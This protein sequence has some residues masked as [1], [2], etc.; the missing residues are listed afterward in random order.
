GAYASMG[1]VNDG[2]GTNGR[3]DHASHWGLP[4]VNIGPQPGPQTQFL[5]TNAD[6]AIFGG[7]AGGGKTYALLL[8]ILRHI[9]NPNFGAVIFRR[10]STQ[11]RNQGGLWHESLGLY[12][13]FGAHPREAFLEWRFPSGMRVKFAHLEHQKTVYEWQGAQVPL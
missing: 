1:L 12:S 13:R 7:A 3:V 2:S 8:E 10:N 6:I 9:D 4:F 11:V 5:T